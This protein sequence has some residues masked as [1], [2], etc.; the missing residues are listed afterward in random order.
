MLRSNSLQIKFKVPSLENIKFLKSRASQSPNCY[1]PTYFSQACSSFSLCQRPPIAMQRNNTS[2]SSLSSNLSGILC[3][4]NRDREA[5]WFLRN[6]R[7]TPR[8]KSEIYLSFHRLIFSCNEFKWATRYSFFFSFFLSSPPS[9]GMNFYFI[10][11]IFQG[12]MAKCVLSVSLSSTLNRHANWLTSREP[13]AV[14]TVLLLTHSNGHLPEDMH[15]NSKIQ[16]CHLSVS[17]LEMIFYASFDV[18]YFD[19]IR[20]HPVSVFPRFCSVHL[21]THS[22][23]LLWILQSKCPLKCFENERSRNN[24]STMQTWIW[25]TL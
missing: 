5:F 23:I 18:F 9:Y 21:I 10:L 4:I 2:S 15:C 13:W 16:F 3:M 11:S 25:F 1:G 7:K 14:F 6:H 12:C 24:I 20:R 8:L 22:D 19:S 17:F